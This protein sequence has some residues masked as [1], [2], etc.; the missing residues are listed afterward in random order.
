MSKA[1]FLEGVLDTLIDGLLDTIDEIDKRN[2]ALAA[3]LRGANEEAAGLRDLKRAVN[4][5][6][7]SWFTKGPAGSYDSVHE[8]FRVAR[9]APTIDP[10]HM[11]R[12][13]SW[14]LENLVFLGDP[15][16]DARIRVI[17]DRFNLSVLWPIDDEGRGVEDVASEAMDGVSDARAKVL[18]EQLLEIMDG[19]VGAGAAEGSLNIPVEHTETVHAFLRRILPLMREVDDRAEADIECD[20][21]T[22][23]FSMAVKDFPES[24]YEPAPIL[25]GEDTGVKTATGECSGRYPYPDWVGTRPDQAGRHEIPRRQ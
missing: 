14:A 21:E 7:R 25:Y 8:V 13:L 20:G 15:D 19:G 12:D 2:Q 6:E 1:S 17:A 5:L 3:K 16:V 24:W 18:A 10:I 9:E 11:Q 23:T 22:I 4:E